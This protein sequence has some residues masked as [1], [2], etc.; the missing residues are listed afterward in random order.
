MVA[1]L[2]PGIDRTPTCKL[3]RSVV[4]LHKILTLCRINGIRTW[5][6]GMWLVCSKMWRRSVFNWTFKPQNLKLFSVC[7]DHTCIHFCLS[8]KIWSNISLMLISS[9]CN[10][11]AIIHCP[12]YRKPT[13]PV[14][15]HQRHNHNLLVT[16][17]WI[18]KQ[19]QNFKYLMMAWG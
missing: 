17:L 11:V 19:K 7:T 5:C 10:Q 4:H 2:T 14:W 13:N 8:F 1:C 16:W 18:A 6:L 12:T 3:C 9:L 15:D